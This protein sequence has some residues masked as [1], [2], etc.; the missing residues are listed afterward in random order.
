MIQK[1]VMPL[2]KRYNI[3]YVQIIISSMGFIWRGGYSLYFN[4][5]VHNEFYDKGTPRWWNSALV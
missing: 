5:M 4:D 3:I 1:I 2:D